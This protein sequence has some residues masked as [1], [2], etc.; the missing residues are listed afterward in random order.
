MLAEHLTLNQDFEG[1]IPSCRTKLFLG[2]Q[3]GKAPDC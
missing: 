3:V 2:S 1:S